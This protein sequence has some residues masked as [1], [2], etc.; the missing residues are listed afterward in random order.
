MYEYETEKVFTR[1]FDRE[2]F[3]RRMVRKNSGAESKKTGAFGIAIVSMCIFSLISLIFLPLMTVEETEYSWDI[4]G[5]TKEDSRW[6]V[7]DFFG[8]EYLFGE[9]YIDEEEW[10]ELKSINAG[11]WQGLW[12][13]IVA[14]LL[15][16]ALIVFGFL[17]TKKDGSKK[18]FAFG[19]G[20]LAIL[21]MVPAVFMMLIGSK[22][23]GMSLSG[24]LSTESNGMIPISPLI[25]GSLG[26][27]IF[28]MSILILRH[29]KNIIK[30]SNTKR[31]LVMPADLSLYGSKTNSMVRL[32]LIAAIL[33]LVTMHLLPIFTYSYDVGG[34][35]HKQM[36]TLQEVA[37]NEVS[38]DMGDA[39]DSF[40][41][42]NTLGWVTFGIVLFIILAHF[43]Y[44]TN[45]TPFTGN[46]LLVCGNIVFIPILIQSIFKVIGIIKTF[47]YESG[48][49]SVYYFF[50]YLPLVAFFCLI[51]A[52]ILFAILSV[53]GLVSFLKKYGKPELRKGPIA[54]SSGIGITEGINY[55]DLE[56]EPW[57]LHVE[58]GSL[59]HI[60]SDTSDPLESE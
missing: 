47:T 11:R 38:G 12:G 3:D 34:E 24:A 48:E 41:I 23:I 58:K 49:G 40:S 13:T 39:I 19:R 36:Y 14:L 32:M 6:K 42:F 29:E 56:V 4:S 17:R 26:I 59:D 1:N 10:D 37:V 15:G 25:V 9:N 60:F 16:I 27:V 5:V 46:I 55:D 31:K 44:I 53:R 7:L 54:S 20:V 2:E 57:D 35:T 51:V 43:F 21:L 30:T 18:G 33:V 45:W 52:S 28:I 8:D 22:W 50:N